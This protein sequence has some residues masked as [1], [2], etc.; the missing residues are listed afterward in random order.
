MA[1]DFITFLKVAVATYLAAKA[2]SAKPI[3]KEAMDLIDYR[4]NKF[5]SSLSKEPVRKLLWWLCKASGVTSGLLFVSLFTILMT[6]DNAPPSLIINLT[7]AFIITLLI[8][9]CVPWNLSHKE[10]IKRIFIQSPLMLIPFTPLI[11][12]VV[13]K[14]TGENLISVFYTIDELDFFVTLAQ[15]NEWLFSIYLFALF[16]MIY[17][18]MPYI[19]FWVILFP[20]FYIFMALIYS[21]QTL[22]NILESRFNENIILCLIAILGVFLTFH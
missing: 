19:Q 8:A 18:V 7:E 13:Q 12:M 3:A 5:L 22:I 17:I 21:A 14:L 4:I 15:G 1:V 2:I 11:A 9:V 6:V 20:L 16:F 10:V